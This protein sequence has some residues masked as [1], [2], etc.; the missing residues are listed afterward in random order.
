MRNQSSLQ[1]KFQVPNRSEEEKRNVAKEK[2]KMIKREF[3]K[4]QLLFAN[5]NNEMLSHVTNQNEEVKVDSSAI[6]APPQEDLTCQHCLDKINVHT[7]TYGVPIYVS[8]TNNLYSSSTKA[9]KFEEQ[10]FTDLS[11]S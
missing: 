6:L 3:A 9:N 8:F 10:D 2:M 11:K 1:N 7:D 4:K 5:K